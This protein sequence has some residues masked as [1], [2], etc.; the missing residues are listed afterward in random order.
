MGT[1]H[2]KALRAASQEAWPD[3]GQTL[4]N[5]VQA[6]YDRSNIGAI[7]AKF[8]G[9]LTHMITGGARW[10]GMRRPPLR[11]STRVKRLNVRMSGSDSH[12]SSLM[13]REHHF[14]AYVPLSWVPA[15]RRV[16][17]CRAAS[18]TRNLLINNRSPFPG[19]CAAPQARS[20]ASSTRYG[21][22]LQ[23]RGPCPGSDTHCLRRRS[24]FIAKA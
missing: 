21:G 24:P 23:S 14:P 18:G 5:A 3:R 12:L 17:S 1:P 10:H 4:G 16:T 11:T 8:R 20:R 19:R 7:F 13:L 2:P 22:A 15:L 9:E 6:R